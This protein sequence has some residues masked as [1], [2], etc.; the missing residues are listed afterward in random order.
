VL[1]KRVPK[2]ASTENAYLGRDCSIL[3]AKREKNGGSVL[4]QENKRRVKSKKIPVY[5]MIFQPVWT[6]CALEFKMACVGLSSDV[7]SASIQNV[8]QPKQLKGIVSAHLECGRI[9][10]LARP[11]ERK[12][13]AVAHIAVVGDLVACAKKRA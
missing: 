2:K 7:R 12:M 13:T 8:L 5:G 6:P 11:R 9:A 4:E 3:A 1:K 10:N